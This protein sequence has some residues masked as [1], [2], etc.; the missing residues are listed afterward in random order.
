MSITKQTD[1]SNIF[2]QQWLILGDSIGKGICF[3]PK[4][5]RHCQIKDCFAERIKNDLNLPLINLSVFGATVDKGLKQ[6]GRYSDRITKGAVSVLQFGGNDCDFD[7]KAISLEPEKEHKP[8]IPLNY[9]AKK[10]QQLIQKLKNMDCQPLILNL[11]PLIHQRYFNFLSRGL[12]KETILSWLGGSTKAIYDWHQAYNDAVEKLAEK[13]N[14]P[15]VDIRSAFLEQ[16]RPEDFIC[17]DGIHPNAKG[18]LLISETMEL[19]LQYN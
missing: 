14:I 12:N 13:E 5:K 18:H 4:R 7:W 17:Q 11:P 8:Q 1:S 6:I 19:Y 9:F 10:Y 3:D 15:L 2:Q 16:Q